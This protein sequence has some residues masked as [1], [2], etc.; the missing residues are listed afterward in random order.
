VFSRPLRSVLFSAS[1][2]AQYNAH[3]HSPFLVLRV[4]RSRW[5]HQ[6]VLLVAMLVGPKQSPRF[7]LIVVLLSPVIRGLCS[8]GGHSTRIA[9]CDF[10]RPKQEAP[11]FL[12]VVIL[13]SLSEVCSRGTDQNLSC[14]LRL[15]VS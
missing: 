14:F 2:V 8:R 5:F 6:L 10:S 15:L 7:F 4:L 9:S 1:L 12:I 3:D 11:V 13:S